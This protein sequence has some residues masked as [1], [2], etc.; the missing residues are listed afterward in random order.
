VTNPHL[1]AN[2]RHRET[3]RSQLAI[4]AAAEVWICLSALQYMGFSDDYCTNGFTPNQV[5]CPYLF[6]GW[7]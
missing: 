4:H 3:R 7:L 6:D 1:A 5:C 2:S